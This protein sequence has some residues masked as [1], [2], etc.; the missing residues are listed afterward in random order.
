MPPAS[1][2]AAGEAHAVCGELDLG[3]GGDDQRSTVR[4]P[5]AVDDARDLLHLDQRELR[6]GEHDDVDLLTVGGVA[7]VEAAH[8]LSADA[9]RA[10]RA[11]APRRLRPRLGASGVTPTMWN[12]ATEP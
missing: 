1:F 10:R 9:V 3:R 7:R 4:D 2:D 5:P 12:S 11:C 8:L 6:R